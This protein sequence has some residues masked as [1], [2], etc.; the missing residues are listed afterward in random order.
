M[1]FA[2]VYSYDP[3]QTGPTEQEF[4]EWL[5]YDKALKDAGIPVYA[6]GFH[7]ATTGKTVS[8]RGG[9]ATTKDAPTSG[10]SVAGF[11]V[12]ELPSMSDALEWAQKV[13]TAKY[14]S[15]EVRQV[16]EF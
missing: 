6:E 15:V 5:E 13:P 7:P 8:V 16:V 10:N 2:L 9:Q 3:T 1:K 12:L 4:P 11:Y 14:G